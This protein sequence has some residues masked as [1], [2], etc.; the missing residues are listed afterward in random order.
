M[1]RRL[2]VTS[3][4]LWGAALLVAAS[5]FASRRMLFGSFR[6]YQIDDNLMMV[7]LVSFYPT[8]CRGKVVKRLIVSTPKVSFTGVIV[9]VNQ[10]A[11][12]GSNY[13]PD[14]LEATWTPQQVAEAEW[15]SKMLLALEQFILATL[16]LVKACLLILYARM[17]LV[18]SRL[19]LP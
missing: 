14:G 11:K 15:G 5:R 13:V 9:A 3:W 8:I 6:E 16:W 17:T 10:V 2:A 4:T 18:P 12:N 19:A 7:C 1:E